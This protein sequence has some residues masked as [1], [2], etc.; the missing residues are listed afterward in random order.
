MT[1]VATYRYLGSA[2]LRPDGLALQ[3]S[4]GP[5]AYPRFSAGFLTTPR[6]AAGGL[7]AVAEGA[8]TRHHRPVDPPGLDP[9]VTGS[10]DRLRFESF[11][12]SCG[13]YARLDVLSTGIDGEIVAHGT[14]TN[15]VV[16]PPLRQAL[17]R[18][19]GVDPLRLSAGP[20]DLTVST[21]DDSVAEKKVPLPPRGLRGFTEVHVLAADFAPRAEIT[22]AD[23]AV[24]LRRLPAGPDRSVPAGRTLRLTTRPTPGAVCLAGA[25]RLTALRGMR[26][27]AKTLRVYGPPVAA[28]SLPTPGTRELD[29]DELRLSPMLSPELYRG[30]SGEGATLTALA[31][32]HVVDD[33]DLVGALLSWD[34]IIDVA[35][36]ATATGI[37]SG[38]V[39]AALAQLGTAGRV[40]YDVSEAAYFRRVQP[41]D[42]GRAERDNPR[43]V[44][45]RALI[46][47][48]AVEI[49]GAVATVRGGDE[50]YRVRIHPDGQH[51]C[52]CPWWTGHHG[53][54]SPCKH[55]LAVSMLVGG[56]EVPA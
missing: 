32:D 23:A 16:N 25:G 56:A 45:A 33:A 20:D 48:K 44:G 11:S 43:L 40:G 35:G 34:P 31:S 38:R 10:R 51:S 7:L 50:S 26:R 18:G 46:E 12:G 3:T 27:F 47:A 28:D 22:A 53:Q 1:A 36:L 6:A 14:T 13:V 30:F 5:L 17:A 42:A 8:R 15:V 2:V 55:A 52:S 21:M 41:Y 54:R 49:D 19:G 24:F 37:D 4:G 29:T 9:V 39:R